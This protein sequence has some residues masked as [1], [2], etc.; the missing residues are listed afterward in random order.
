[1]FP[2]FRYLIHGLTGAWP[3][4]W[5]ALF[6]TFGLMVALAFIAASMVLI[7]ELKRKEKEGLMQ[8]TITTVEEGKP[9]TTTEILLSVLGGFLLGYK[10]G[11]F[12]GHWQQIAPDPA[13]YLFS[14]QGNLPAGILVAALLGYLKYREKKKAALAKPVTKKVATWPHQR[15]GEVVLI[16]AVAGIIGAKIFNALETWD[17]FIAD[18]IGSLTSSAGLTF[19]GG[20]LAATAV[21]YFFAK[22][23]KIRFAHLADAAGPAILLAYGLGRLGCQ[24]SGDGDWGIYNSAYVTQADGTLTAAPKGETIAF[25]ETTGAPHAFIAAPGWLPRSFVAQNYRHNVLN[26]GMRLPDCQ[27]DYCA[28]LPVSVFPTPLYE[29]VACVLLFSLLWSIRRKLRK[30]WQMFALFLIAMGVERF[31]VELIRVN[32]TYDLGIIQPTQAE[33]ISTFLVLTGLILFF[34]SKKLAPEP[35]VSDG[36]KE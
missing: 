14:A 12:F 17:Q 19:Y 10:A 26:E 13:N 5:L 22:K 9:A 18:P 4:E 24:L 15:I 23:H 31:F 34:R 7:R 6:K 2:D 8:P 21:F 36:E 16:A 33:I 1:M 11:G 29:T 3:P 20:F 32:T 27:G 25:L 35:M 30:P 28:V